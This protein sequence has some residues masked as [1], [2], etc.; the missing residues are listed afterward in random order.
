M[1]PNGADYGVGKLADVVPS[2]LAGMGV[3][4]M[5]PGLAEAE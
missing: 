4:G 5:S 3:P 2:L 1:E